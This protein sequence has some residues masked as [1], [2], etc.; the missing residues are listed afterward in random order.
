MSAGVLAT[1]SR[2]G[3]EPTT[4]GM[5]GSPAS[6]GGSGT[7]PRRGDRGRRGRR[8]RRRGQRRGRRDVGRHRGASR[9]EVG[10]AFMGE[11]RTRPSRAETSMVA[12]SLPRSGP[13]RF[14]S[15]L[16]PAAAPPIRSQRRRSGELIAR[17]DAVLSIDARAIGAGTGGPVGAPPWGSSGAS[18]GPEPGPARAG[19]PARGGA[20]ALPRCELALRRWRERVLRQGGRRRRSLAD[21]GDGD[22][23]GGGPATTLVDVDQRFLVARRAEEVAGLLVERAVDEPRRLIVRFISGFAGRRSSNPGVRDSDRRPGS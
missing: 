15:R 2:H 16:A 4:G 13:A 22:S 8:R 1:V 14:R 23:A 21:R 10:E 20:R 3:P 18:S 6:S 19:T 9:R 12:P 5:L 11:P 17:S 7:I